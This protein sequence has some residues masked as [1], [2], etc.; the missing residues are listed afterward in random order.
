MWAVWRHV[1]GGPESGSS[2]RP[3][4]SAHRSQ[5]RLLP[6][7]LWAHGHHRAGPHHRRWGGHLQ[8][9]PGVR[10]IIFCLFWKSFARVCSFQLLDVCPCPV[11]YSAFCLFCII[12]LSG[13][14]F[15]CRFL[16]VDKVSL[17][18][19][20]VTSLHYLGRKYDVE[21]LVQ[22]CLEF[23]HA[24]LTADTACTILEQA[25]CFD[26]HELYKTS[27]EFVGVN[28]ELCL[29][30]PSLHDLC[31]W[32]VLPLSTRWEVASIGE[33][34][35]LAALIERLPLSVSCPPLQHLLRGC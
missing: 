5:P 31:R 4:V 20:N 17:T 3:Q 10:K 15:G 6:H 12:S 7:V 14:T 28:A 35:S 16:Y 27:F 13:W 11:V 21:P 18:S 23:L 33:L 32:V 25:H 8:N 26:E 29:A 19:D 9:F 34:S 2:G 24:R 22:Q 1:P 30:S